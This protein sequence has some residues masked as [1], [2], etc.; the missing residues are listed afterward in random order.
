MARSFLLEKEKEIDNA[1]ETL[2]AKYNVNTETT[3]ILRDQL[4][5]H[6]NYFYVYIYWLEFRPEAFSDTFRSRPILLYTVPLF[7]IWH[8]VLPHGCVPQNYFMLLS[9]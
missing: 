4:V 1:N 2:Q 3:A 7:M 5:Y 9:F 6:I 8:Q